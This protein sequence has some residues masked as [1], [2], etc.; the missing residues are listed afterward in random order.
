MERDP[1]GAARLYIRVAVL[2]FRRSSTYR[3]ATLGGAA[4]NTVVAFLLASV[5]L[6]TVSQRGS[7]HGLDATGA[8]TFMFVVFGLDAPV[9]VFQALELGDRIRSGD[10][11]VDLY[12]P[13]DTQLYWLAQEVGRAAFATLTRLAPPLLIGGLVFA[14]RVP[15]R[16]TTWLAFAASLGA[17]VAFSFAYRFVIS[18]AA[19]WMLDA[20]GVYSISGLFVMGL[21]GFVI[22]LQLLPPWVSSIA[23]NLPFAALAQ[24]PAEVFLGMHPGLGGLLAVVARQVAWTVAF[25]VIGRMLLGAGMRRLVVQGG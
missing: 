2:S 9:G 15:P 20:R 8:V 21:S 25:A 1:A 12:R 18:L 7:I 6:A 16:F 22:P 14:V 23:R 19:F 3:V 13:L 4:A 11:A 24:F 17:A 5:L 10:V